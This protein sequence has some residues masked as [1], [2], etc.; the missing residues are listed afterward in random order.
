MREDLLDDQRNFDAG[1]DLDGAAAASADL[2]ADIEH[3][4]L[5]LR[6]GQAFLWRIVATA[7][8]Q[9]A[10][11]DLDGTLLRWRCST[12]TGVASRR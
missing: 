6:P 1:N 11:K 3:P 2:D 8:C 10:V 9:D 4:L 12:C 5:A 7:T